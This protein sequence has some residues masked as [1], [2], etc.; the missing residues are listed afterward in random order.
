ME[1]PLSYSRF[2]EFLK[3]GLICGIKCKK[4]GC[5]YAPPVLYCDE[6]HSSSFD[7]IELKGIAEI[8]T[9]TIVRIPP[10]PF[11][12][13]RIVCISRLPEGPRLMGNLIGVECDSV[14]LEIIGKKV[15][16]GYQGVDGDLLSGGERIAITFTFD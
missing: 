2:V 8:E 13:P 14:N 9:F 12:S 16:I 6:C 1:Y 4:C 11:S 15:K 10:E 5:V 3:E 7:L